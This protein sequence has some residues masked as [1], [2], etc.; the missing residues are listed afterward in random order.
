LAPRDAALIAFYQPYFN[1]TAAALGLLCTS[2]YLLPA[3]GGL[4]FLNIANTSEY[5]WDRNLYLFYFNFMQNILKYF[6]P[7]QF[8]K[9]RFVFYFLIKTIIHN[10]FIL[11]RFVQYLFNRSLWADEAVLVNI[12]N[13]R[14]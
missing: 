6:T 9:K 5:S 3:I 8:S 13:V 11:V 1:P 12:S 4:P 7:S 10:C 2:R 14:I